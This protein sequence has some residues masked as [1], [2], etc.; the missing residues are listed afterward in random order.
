MWLRK[1]VEFLISSSFPAL[2]ININ[3]KKDRCNFGFSQIVERL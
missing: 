2:N 1:K 3:G